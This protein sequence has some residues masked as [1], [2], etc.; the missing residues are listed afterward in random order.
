[1]FEPHRREFLSTQTAGLIACYFF[2]V[3]ALG[4]QRLYAL[5]FLVHHTLRLHGAGVTA[6]PTA[7]RIV[8]EAPRLELDDTGLGH[9]SRTLAL[10]RQASSTQAEANRPIVSG[11]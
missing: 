6:H 9:S 2:H 4:P 3:D 1:M 7:I 8:G 10:E 11:N 5:V